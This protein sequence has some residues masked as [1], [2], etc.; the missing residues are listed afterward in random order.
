MWF[1][2]VFEFD[3]S[4]RNHFLVPWEKWTRKALS[5]QK[6]VWQLLPWGQEWGTSALNSNQ[7]ISKAVEEK[8]KGFYVFSMKGYFWKVIRPLARKTQYMQKKKGRRKSIPFELDRSIE[9]GRRKRENNKTSN[10]RS[11]NIRKALWVPR[12]TN[13]SHWKKENSGYW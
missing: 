12:N 7:F 6:C 1:Y 5:T 2:F 13:K 10:Y 11:R 8:S 9:K 3:F 4:Q